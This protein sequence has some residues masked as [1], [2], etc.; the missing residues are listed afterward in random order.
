MGLLILLW[1]LCGGGRGRAADLL[2][3]RPLRVLSG[4]RG[5][6][7]GSGEGGADPQPGFGDGVGVFP[8]VVDTDLDLPGAAGD[9]GGDVQ[10]EVAEG[11][12]LV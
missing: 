1:V 3:C 4:R 12:D 10:Y 8:G 11:A 2:W 9:A 7:F 5:K 6:E